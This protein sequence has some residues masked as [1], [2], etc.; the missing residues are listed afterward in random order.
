MNKNEAKL[1]AKRLTKGSKGEIKIKRLVN[2][3]KGIM[4]EKYGLT[5]PLISHIPE[6]ERIHFLFLARNKCPVVRY[7]NDSGLFSSSRETPF[8]NGQIK[9][10]DISSSKKGSYFSLITNNRIALITGI[11]FGDGT[12][13]TNEAF[14]RKYNQITNVTVNKGA[15]KVSMEIEDTE[16]RKIK[17]W[18]QPDEWKDMKSAK[19]YI[20]G[21]ISDSFS[22]D[23]DFGSSKQS[24]STINKNSDINNLDPEEFEHYVADI[25]KDKGWKVEVTQSSKDKGIDVIATKSDPFQ[26]KQLIQAKRYDKQNPVNSTEVQQYA[27]LYQQEKNVDSVI[28]VTSSY[29]TSDAKHRADDLNVKLINGEKL[30]QMAS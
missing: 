27:S 30:E 25:W 17:F 3:T 24:Q 2:A 22:S 28:I 26:Q 14:E 13:V 6:G 12:P 23:Y 11:H 5:D 18:G 15:T 1:K 21:R 4:S 19:S 8:S 10:K 9:G 16:G 29:F 20:Q 7:P